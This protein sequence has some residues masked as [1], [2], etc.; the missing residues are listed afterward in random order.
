NTETDPV[1]SFVGVA[2][3]E[4]AGGVINRDLFS[5]EMTGYMTDPVLLDT[6]AVAKLKPHAN[7]L[8]KQGSAWVEIRVRFDSA[9]LADYHKART[10]R[11]APSPAQKAALDQIDVELVAV[12]EEMARLQ[13]ADDDVE[14]EDADDVEPD[15]EACDTSALNAKRQAL[16]AQRNGITDTLLQ[17]LPADVALA[18][19]VVT[20][21]RQG[22]VF[23]HRNL[24]RAADKS[25]MGKVAGA[26]A[27]GDESQKPKAPKAVHSERLV[28]LMTSH[29][30]AALRAEVMVKPDVAL[31]VLTHALVRD[32]FFARGYSQAITQIALK[33]PT[34]DDTIEDSPACAVFEAKRAALAAMLP[35]DAE[36]LFCWLQQQSQTL[37]LELMAFCTA[38]ALDAVQGRESPSQAFVEIAKAVDLKMGDWWKPTAAN[39]FSHVS[40]SRVIDVVSQAISPQAAAPLGA[41]KKELAAQAAERA[42]AASSWLP[43]VHQ[44]A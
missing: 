44:T 5:T 32:V 33:G 30:T 38:Y 23:V 17:L 7:K 15:G 42:L 6:L 40:K 18:G 19:A 3:Y 21:D 4:K 31:V 27:F 22:K 14:D 41:M 36:L 13:P 1:A 43:E 16:R 2:A 20:I 12:N 10:A 24:I 37:V 29:R 11:A 26:E 35:A 8:E 25:K 9:A 28:R 34:L 39:Y